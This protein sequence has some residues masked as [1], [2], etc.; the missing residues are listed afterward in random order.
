MAMVNAIDSFLPEDFIQHV[1]LSVVMTAV[2]KIHVI[3]VRR[4]MLIMEVI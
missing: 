1:N 3:F 4:E 2:R